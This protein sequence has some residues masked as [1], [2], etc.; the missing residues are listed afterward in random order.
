MA[1]HVEPL[2]AFGVH[3][4]VGVD[5]QLEGDVDEQLRETD[6]QDDPPVESHDEQHNQAAARDEDGLQDKREQ[7]QGAARVFLP[8]QLA[9]SQHLHFEEG[10]EICGHR[11]DEDDEQVDCEVA[12]LVVGGLEALEQEDAAAPPVKLH[13]HHL[14]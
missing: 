2:F 5:R 8:E 10:E 13:L 4:A 11:Q 3:L 1:A 7:L 14:A 12:A 9:S 6:R